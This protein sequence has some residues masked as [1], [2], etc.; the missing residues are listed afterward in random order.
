MILSGTR[1]DEDVV[2]WWLND[3]K[4]RANTRESLGRY[5]GLDV[6]SLV[7]SFYMRPALREQGLSRWYP[8]RSV[9]MSNGE[10][11]SGS[12]PEKNRGNSVIG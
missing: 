4:P 6:F 3:S 9:G 12:Q 11:G 7:L 1:A 10:L 2:R 5:A 8:L